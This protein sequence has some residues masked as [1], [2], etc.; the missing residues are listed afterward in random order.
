MGY[1]PTEAP[2]S[3]LY[4]HGLLFGPTPVTHTGV[5]LT[6][7]FSPEWSAYFALVEGWDVFED[8]N[9]AHSYMA[10]GAWQGADKLG[11]KPVHA[12][13]FCIMTGPEQDDNVHHYRTEMDAY[14][15]R[16]WTQRLSQTLE[17]EF[18]TEEG[19]SE[20][21]ERD[22]WYGL[23]HYLSYIFD[24]AVTGTWRAG[25]LRDEHGSQT[26]LSGNLFENTLG[27]SLTPW[28]Q[29]KVL[30]NLTFRPEFRW[31]FACEP[32][33]GGDRR[34]QLTAAIDLIFKF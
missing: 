13:A 24:D 11:D 25:W 14:Y 3:P 6:Y 28:P 20:G 16:W 8:N 2:L 21:G 4:S 12:A 27:V 29:D 22:R 18:A 10:G 7:T 23:S 30:R 17:A 1:E 31:D 32:A 9:D 26:G 33:F 15:T 19:A 5:K 34:N